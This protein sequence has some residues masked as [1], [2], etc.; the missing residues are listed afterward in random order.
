MDG[1]EGDG[2]CGGSGCI[3]IACSEPAEDAYPSE[4]A[5]VMFQRSQV[6]F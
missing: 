6:C 2:G 3:N 5:A 4:G 1:G